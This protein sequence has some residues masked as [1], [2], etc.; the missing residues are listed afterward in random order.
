MTVTQVLVITGAFIVAWS[1][2]Y[3]D[4][5]SEGATHA[6]IGSTSFSPAAFERE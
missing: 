4:A 5:S 2:F 1:S 3:Q 6:S